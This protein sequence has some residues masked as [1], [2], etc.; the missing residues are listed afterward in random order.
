[1]YSGLQQGAERFGRNGCGGTAAETGSGFYRGK[2]DLF[3]R[4]NIRYPQAGKERRIFP[5]SGR[6]LVQA[7]GKAS[8][9]F[10]RSGGESGCLHFT[11]KGACA[12]FWH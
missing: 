5:V 1:M 3:K 12:V 7:E 11:D 6:K 4:G 2:T 8:L 10:G 9:F